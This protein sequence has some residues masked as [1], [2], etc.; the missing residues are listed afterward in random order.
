MPAV[1]RSL[2]SLALLLAP[3]GIRAAHADGYG[4]AV[5]RTVVPDAGHVPV[6]TKPPQLLTS[7]QPIF[8]ESAKAQ[9]L[10]G[11]VTMQVD[12]G[13][14]G[15]VTNVT[16]LEP[17]GHGFDEAAV[18]AVKQFVFSP[19]EIDGKPAP[20]RIGYTQHFVWT[21]PPDAGPPPAPDAG[22][23]DAG[24]RW[25]VRLAGRVLERATRKPVAGAL[26]QAAGDGGSAEFVSDLSGHFELA[27]PPGKVN[28]TIQAAGYRHYQTTED[29]A[30]KEQLDATYFL[31]PTT[32]G[33]YESVVH[34]TRDKKE[35]TRRT[36]SRAELERVPGTMGDPIRV[37]QDLPGVARAP[38]LSGALIVRGAS[39]NDTGSYI[40]GVEIPLLFHFFGGPS[41]VNPEFLDRI[42]FY[43]GGFGPEYGRAIGGIVDVQTR[44]PK[45]NTWQGSAKI[46]LIDTGIYVAAPVADGLSVSVSARR[47]YLDAVLGVALDVAGTTGI[48]VAPVYYDYQLRVD[49]AP[50]KH[51]HNRFKVFGFGS[52][53]LLTAVSSGADSSLDFKVN[54][55]TAFQRLEGQWI[56]HD[57]RT[58]LTTT[59]FVGHD[60]LSFGLG[61]FKVTDTNW[62]AGWRE[63]LELAFT[64][65]F[66]WR[67]GLDLELNRSGFS[68]EFPAQPL[69]YR[70]FP[71]EAPVASTQTLGG[72]IDELDWGVWTEGEL[73][74][75][76]RVKVIPGL[77][78]DYF[79]LH[80]AS[81]PSVDPRL[82]IRKDFGS[83][84]KPLTLKGA[85][86]LYHE[87]PGAQNL[88]P[89][90]GNPNEPLQAAFQTSVGVEKKITSAINVD[91]TGF[92]NRR[93]QL[94]ESANQLEVQPDGTLHRVLVEP[95]GLGKAYGVE[96]LL[97]HEI[98]KHFFGWLAYTLSWSQERDK[99]GDDYAPA[100]FDERHI[101]T[102]IAQYKFG[103]GWEVG[104]RYRLAT[105]IPDTPTVGATFDADTGSYQPISGAAGSTRQPT[106]SQL[107]LRVDKTWLLDRFKI[108]VYLDIQNVLNETNREGLISDYRFRTTETVPGIP[109]LPNIGVKGS[110]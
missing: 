71:G 81:R 61:P 75:P 54:E 89:T 82:T 15:K 40:D 39:P 7:V 107:D 53:D 91:V 12:I 34:G 52:D 109:F 96:V 24:P 29:I 8:P 80:G 99:P 101:L 78:F 47:S 42:D 28:V 88:D 110:F 35:V 77:R 32:Y 100:T 79:R 49:Y 87:S 57:G 72:V 11:D 58:T 74:L 17:A 14:D 59:P 23:P 86:G 98:T 65:A 18:A 66:T 73:K 6:L 33:L 36:L 51:P 68:A 38:F 85:I 70:P 104:G 55:H 46:D 102:L 25:P 84:D 9:Q 44:A 31:M 106:F 95:Y 19:A 62:V 27:L 45:P 60:L 64:K 5:E 3:I 56:W 90:F 105:G 48:S 22:T 50:P 1:L 92:F 41:V 103:N 37:I 108:G 10:Q 93:Y 67:L 30:A 97:R 20:V 83:V 4:G 76:W 63:K 21:A 69:D 16:V 43:P 94:A 13:A 26:V 2:L